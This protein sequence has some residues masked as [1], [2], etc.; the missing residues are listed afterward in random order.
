MDVRRWLVFV[1]VALLAAVVVAGC[2]PADTDNGTEGEDNG[3]EEAATDPTPLIEAWAESTHAVP[4]ATVAVREGCA[5]CHD[6]RAFAQDIEDPT[7]F[8]APFGPYVVATDCRACHTGQGAELLESGQVEI[9]SSPDPV[10]AGRGAL[11]MACHNQ[12]EVADINNE[13]RSYPHYG[14]M[15]DVLNG[16]G[17]ILDNLTVL[18]T[19]AHREIEDTCVTCHM[20]GEGAGHSFQPSEEQCQECHDDFE[21][22]DAFEAGGDY[23]GDGSAE[24]FVTEVE[25][26]MEALEGAVNENAGTTEFVTFRG[27]IVFLSNDETVT[28]GIAPEAYQGAYNWVLIDHDRSR[29]VHNPFFTVTLLQETYRQ[30]TGSE[31]PNAVV[32]E[33]EEE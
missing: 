26:L 28:A 20:S 10:E 2:Q 17:G 15:A 33:P 21:S 13:E 16:T 1:L 14:T 29:G 19:D 8:E 11:C 9:P 31:L 12:E 27:E 23:D 7:G 3:G 25:G 6:G 5:G 18:S 24:A 4:V 32:P 30:V 22:I